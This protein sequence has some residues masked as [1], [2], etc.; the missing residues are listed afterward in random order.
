VDQL[1]LDLNPQPRA[2][3][4]DPDTSHQAAKK[5]GGI[6]VSHR[7]RIMAVLREGKGNIYQI[8]AKANLSHV[9]VARRMIELERMG[10][11][12]PTEERSE[13]CRV[14]EAVEPKL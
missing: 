13:G 8:G 7:N 6:A 9:A 1:G 10:Q 12:R 14:W 3:R 5:A 2:R 4:K 11:A